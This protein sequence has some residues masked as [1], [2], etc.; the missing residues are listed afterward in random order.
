MD[1]TPIMKVKFN[2]KGDLDS[3]SGALCH[4]VCPSRESSN[5]ELMDFFFKTNS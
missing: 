4:L 3:S 5:F 2:G 1:R